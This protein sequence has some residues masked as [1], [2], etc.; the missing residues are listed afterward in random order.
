MSWLLS[1]VVT[2]LTGVLGLLVG[3]LV[4]SL[5]VDWYGISSFEGGSGYFVV[6]MALL[7]LLAG[8]VVGLISARLA[9]DA[10][11]VR[12]LGTSSLVVLGAAFA[13]GGVSRWL[14]DVPPSIDGEELVLAFELRWPASATQP[15]A[16][17]QGLGHARLGAANGGQV[18]RWGSGILFVEDAHR[19]DGRWVVPGAVKV[20][21]T[22]G[23]RVLD[24][25]IGDSTLAG[26]VVPLPGSPGT[27]ER[28]WSEWLPRARAGEPA[29]PDGYRYR[30]R[31][32]KASEP[33]REE[34]I[35]PFTVLTS[36]SGFYSSAL[37]EAPAATSRLQLRYRET[38]I[39]G[40]DDLGAVALLPGEPTT[41][42]VKSGGSSETGECQL[43]SERDGAPWLRPA[44][45]CAGQIAGDLLTADA[46]AWHEARRDPA[47][48]G[49]L[50]R[51]TFRIPGLY[52]LPEGILDTRTHT[53]VESEPPTEPSPINGLPPIALSPDEESYAWFTQEGEQAAP[54]LC[55]TNWRE[56][57][58]YT[59]PI[60]R[61]RM[62]FNAYDRL[63]PAWVARHFEWLRAPDGA[64][65]LAAREHFTPLPYVGDREIDSGGVMASYY[66]K[67]GGTALR[68]AMVEAM[69]RELGATREPDELDGYH[70]VVRYEGKLI[71]SAVVE[72]GG[73]V[74]IG[75]DFGSEDSALMVRLADRL[76]ALLATGRFDEFFHLDV[77][78]PP[79]S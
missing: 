66:L 12:A 30:F 49:W 8:A 6:G 34:A 23:T 52:R 55:V 78:E 57:H 53:F 45:S 67:P 2:L 47:A 22:R 20:F 32:V 41:F 64:W 48:A 31:I 36:V 58:T 18:R 5:A 77:K 1:F 42:L 25:G 3:G 69:V 28:E 65:T 63:D 24:V 37:H 29:L 60:D 16:G 72:S 70:K 33:A 54:V 38:D 15:A 17:T 79:S 73:F 50:D 68:D 13:I 59:L 43:V 40:L 35:G 44:G 10:G 71:K 76:D 4:A 7:G 19:V 14:A 46:V 9:G 74:S 61:S 11:M 21:T 51:R 39:P 27:K 75:M 26:F 62:R 56:Q